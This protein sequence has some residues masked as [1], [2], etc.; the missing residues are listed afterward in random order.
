[1]TT[2]RKEWKELMK[3]WIEGLMGWFGLHYY[4]PLLKVVQLFSGTLI[5]SPS[6]PWWNSQSPSPSPAATKMFPFQPSNKTPSSATTADLLTA[7]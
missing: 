3:T 7:L 2:N 6:Q 4:P 1:M 5:V